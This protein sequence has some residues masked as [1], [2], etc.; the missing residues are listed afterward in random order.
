MRSAVSVNL[1]LPLLFDALQA[2]LQK[3]NLQ[4]LLTD[5]ALQLGHA[6]FFPAPL[7]RARKRIP[8]PIPE[9]ASPA[10]QDIGVDLNPL[11]SS[12]I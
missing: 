12:A 7:A 4:R 5:L 11:A 1:Q 3:T 2:P 9:L 6:V 10:M 8:R